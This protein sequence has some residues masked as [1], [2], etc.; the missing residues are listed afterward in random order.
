L[1]KNSSIGELTDIKKMLTGLIK[2]L[3]ETKS[4]AKARA[5]AASC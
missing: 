2:R 1:L 4:P 5:G 3:D